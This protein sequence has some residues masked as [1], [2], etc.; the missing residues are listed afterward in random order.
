MAAAASRYQANPGTVA[1]A[2][3]IERVARTAQPVLR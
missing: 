1:A 3:R 2:D